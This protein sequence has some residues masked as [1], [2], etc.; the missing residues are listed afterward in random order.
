VVSLAR[1]P[2]FVGRQ[3][4]IRKLEELITMQDGPRRIAI[5]GL[6]G[7]GKTQVALEIAYRIRDQD[8]ECSIFWIPCTSHAMIEQT[9]L[10]IAQTLGLR[11]VKPAEVQEQIKIY[12]SSERAGKWLLIFDNADDTE[13]W[14]TAN[15]KVPAFEDLLPETENSP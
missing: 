15:N 1:N 14:L 11:D 13:M 8:K 6:G 10:N 7:V 2:K 9:F 5:T 4:E 12:L 3:D